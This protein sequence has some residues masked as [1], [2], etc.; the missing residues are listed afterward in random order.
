V[1]DLAWVVLGLSIAYL[2][3]AGYLLSLEVRRRRLDDAGGWP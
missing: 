1:S 3:M 2:S